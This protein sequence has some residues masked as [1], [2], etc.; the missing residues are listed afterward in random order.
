MDEMTTDTRAPISQTLLP[1]FC[2]PIPIIPDSGLHVFPA[3]ASLG[4][5]GPTPEH[6]HHLKSLH[7]CKDFFSYVA[8]TSRIVRKVNCIRILSG[9]MFLLLSNINPDRRPNRFPSSPQQYPA[10][11]DLPRSFLLFH[12]FAPSV[13]FSSYLV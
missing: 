3:V 13:Y 10:R 9:C 5:C 1:S 7:V 4:I 12:E 6:G 8:S 2:S 11:D